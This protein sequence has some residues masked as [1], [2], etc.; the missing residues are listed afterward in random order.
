[1]MV[2]DLREFIFEKCSTRIGFSKKGSYYWLKK[3]KKNIKD[4]LLLI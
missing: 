1:M 3:A 2:K 4:C